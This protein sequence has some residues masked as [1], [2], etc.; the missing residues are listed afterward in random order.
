M[1]RGR[2]SSNGA[3]VAQDQWGG[4]R[5]DLDPSELGFTGALDM[6]DVDLKQ[7]GLLRARRGFQRW[8]SISGL[9][10]DVNFM[11]AASI[12]M[13]IAAGLDLR[14]YSII[15]GTF[16]SNITLTTGA[17]DCLEYAIGAAAP[18]LYVCSGFS[19]DTIKEVQFAAWSSNATIPKCVLLARTHA[20]NRMVAL[21]TDGATEIKFSDPDNPASWPATNFEK[22][23]PGVGGYKYMAAVLWREMLFIFRE[24]AFLIFSGTSTDSSGGAI[25]DFRTVDYGVGAVALR[26]A[27]AAPEG[28]YFLAGDG[29]Y[30]TRGGA[31]ERVSDPVRSVW[32]GE[33]PAELTQISGDPYLGSTTYGPNGVSMV[34]HDGDILIAYDAT[35]SGGGPGFT[36]AFNTL[37]RTWSLWSRHPA[38]MTA[39]DDRFLQSLNPAVT[40][41][42]AVWMAGDGTD[43][44]AVYRMQTGRGQ[45]YNPPTAD[46]RDFLW[47]YRTGYTDF[48]APG[49][50]TLRRTLVD[51]VCQAN[52]SR[53]LY[54]EHNTLLSYANELVTLGSSRTQK[55]W[56]KSGRA[57]A[58]SVRLDGQGDVTLNRLE[59][60]VQRLR[61][62]LLDTA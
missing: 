8:A 13:V 50:K 39:M 4:L 46:V 61:E 30:L 14:L 42:P 44:N 20:D 43:R 28:V 40:Q 19:G 34:H 49:E 47:L 24:K 29:L 27:C 1:A 45:D 15:N 60:Y 16:V 12:G 62:P 22:P 35:G 11:Q 17:R 5:L 2:S 26:A 55:W 23:S 53:I 59:H 51:G 31:P 25:F 56:Q 54:D 10:A 18:K 3:V 38:A 6:R 37:T 48:G 7:A 58:F 32:S 9:A 36:L 21:G 57:R 52:I 41:S 33:R